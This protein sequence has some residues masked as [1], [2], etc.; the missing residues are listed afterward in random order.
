MRNEPKLEPGKWPQHERR[1][2]WLVD[3]NGR[4]TLTFL[5]AGGLFNLGFN[6]PDLGQE[7]AA[8]V[9]AG[10]VGI[11]MMASQQRREGEAAFARLLPEE[12]K[13]TY[14]APSA[15]E[16]FEVACKLAK[17]YTGRPN[18]LSA[19]GGYHGHL[20]FS[21][22]MDDDLF[23]PE[24]YAPLA[25]PVP[26]FE[27]GDLP[28]LDRKLDSSVAAVCLEPLQVPGGVRE[29]PPGFL[30]DVRRLCDERGAL[31]ILDEVQAGLYRTG[32]RWSFEQHG[33]VPDI[34][35]SGKGISGGYYPMGAMSCR[36]ELYQLLRQSPA[37][38]LSTFA[39]SEIAAGVARAVSERYVDAGL[40]EHVAG[41]GAHLQSG[42]QQLIAR[43]PGHLEQLR[44]RGLVY[45]FDV[46]GPDAAPLVQACRRQGLLLQACLLSQR[47]VSIVPPLI[48]STEEIDEGLRRLT[49]AVEQSLELPGSK[50]V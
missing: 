1:G 17:R 27:F 10:D 28:D 48:I 33:I 22:A 14:F 5:A 16:V 3:E 29:A 35:I 18:L 4:E 40:A 11:G 43:F 46:T 41:V 6:P 49:A 44:G 19:T 50:S 31:L 39:G 12:L 20:G 24:L 21:L 8:L 30:E 37:L 34:L 26:R 23:Q 36:T 15:S 9:Q 42:L 47:T 45:G 2:C 13:R 7:I 32:T 25:G 38:H